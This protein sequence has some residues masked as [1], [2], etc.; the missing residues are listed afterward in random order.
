MRRVRWCLPMRFAVSPSLPAAMAALALGLFA[1]ALPQPAAAMCGGNILMTC[2]AKA[3]Q[4]AG[5]RETRSKPRKRKLPAS[6]ARG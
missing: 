3:H 6:T 2:P 1:T 4:P 5:I